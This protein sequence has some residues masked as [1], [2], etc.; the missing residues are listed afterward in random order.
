M[1]TGFIIEEKLTKLAQEVADEYRRG[2]AELEGLVSSK[3]SKS[4]LNN[5]ETEV[6]NQKVNHLVFKEKF[7][8]DKTSTFK[9]SKFENILK[10]DRTMNIVEY[11]VAA[12]YE[13]EMEKAA[14]FEDGTQ[15]AAKVD[16]TPQNAALMMEA[17]EKNIDDIQD[18]G[19]QREGALD[20]IKHRVVELLK[21]GE[22][23]STI[24]SVLNDSWGDENKDELR[25]YFDQLVEELKTEGV[26]S[27][28]AYHEYARPRDI[29]DSEPLK[30]ASY[31]LL[32][33]S[34]ELIK[35]ECAH[36]IIVTKL[37]NDGYEIMA[38]KLEDK[39]NKGY[40]K[41]TYMLS[42][43]AAQQLPVHVSQAVKSALLGGL[44]L[45][46]ALKGLQ[47]TNSGIDKIRQVLWKDKLKKM[48]PELSQIPENKYTDIYGSI[49]GLEPGLLKAPYALK[50]MIMAHH[51]YGTIDSRTTLS[52]LQSGRD[53]HPNTPL[54]A[55]TMG[56]AMMA[57]PE[58]Y[59][60]SPPTP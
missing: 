59:V 1:S 34:D 13:N 33:A 44:V 27:D 53:A 47:A 10:V 7:A 22:S 50:E 29:A 60:M 15:D 43:L 58:L 16:M 46:G 57:N 31:H 5:H 55:K 12:H 3:A 19:N 32:E 21:N 35:R 24:F 9:I 49:T 18:I 54:I 36:E 37:A 14:E 40:Y 30:Q 48:Y 45:A 6:L 38:H 41:N 25:H 11:K 4:L 56:T 17:G 2:G 51:Q 26:V 39:M 8:D 23:L 52:L 20:N 42:K 28:G